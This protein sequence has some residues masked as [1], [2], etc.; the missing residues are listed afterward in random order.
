MSTHLTSPFPTSIAFQAWNAEPAITVNFEVEGIVV[1]NNLIRAQVIGQ[2]TLSTAITDATSTTKPSL[3]VDTAIPGNG[4][5]IDSEVFL[6]LSNGTVQRGML[7]TV[8]AT[9]LSGA[10]VTIIRAGSFTQFLANVF[11]DT[12]LS[13]KASF[14]GPTV[15]AA[16]AAIAAQEAIIAATQL[17][18]IAAA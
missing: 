18:S 11:Q 16:Q 13:A 5:I 3:S 8:P 4:L 7:L 15:Q 10:A 6:I 12:A 14:P 2:T 9:H 17:L 1:S